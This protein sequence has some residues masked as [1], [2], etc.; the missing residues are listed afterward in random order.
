MQFPGLALSEGLEIDEGVYRQ[1]IQA[2][3]SGRIGLVAV[4]R[5]AD[6]PHRIGSQGA[7]N[8]FMDGDGPTLL[9][10]MMRSWEDRFDARLFRLGFDTMQFLVRRPPRSEASAQ[11]V[12]AEHFAL[13]GQDSVGSIRRHA[14]QITN[15]PT[16]DFWWD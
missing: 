11:A 2:T 5:P 14:S 10:V 8:H 16:W 3:P 9:S 7:V 1:A 15:C 12:A 6:V 13:A 4:D